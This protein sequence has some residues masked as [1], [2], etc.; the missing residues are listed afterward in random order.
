MDLDELQALMRGLA[1]VRPVFHSEADFQHA[2]AWELHRRHPEASI[3][4][5]RQVLPALYL[6]LSVTVA[7]RTTAIEL[8]Y[9]TRRFAIDVGGEHFQLR[10]HSAHDVRRYDVIKDIVRVERVVGERAADDGFVILLT[11]DAGY[12]REGARATTADASFRLHDG[13]TIRGS[14]AWAASAGAG[15]IK[16]REVELSLLSEYVTSWRDYSRLEGSAG[17]FRYLAI[18]VRPQ[19]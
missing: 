19:P 16:G 12:W 10:D 6:D 9:A 14:L 15:T 5:E 11:N 3:R 8:K 13:R 18:E 2:V 7:G 17:V 4:L 1:A